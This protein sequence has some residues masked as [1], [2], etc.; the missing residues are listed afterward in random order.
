MEEI[1][2]AG[3][4]AAGMKAAGSRAGQRQDRSSEQCEDAV[5]VLL[6][7]SV[8]DGDRRWSATLAGVQMFVT[9][10]SRGQSEPQKGHSAGI[11]PPPGHV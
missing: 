7:L 11:P 2:G 8:M 6:Q 4:Q 10:G 9:P 5:S 1:T 3:R